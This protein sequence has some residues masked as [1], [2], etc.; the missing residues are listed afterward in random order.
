MCIEG[1]GGGTNRILGGI[2]QSLYLSSC[3]NLCQFVQI[4][5]RILY[6]VRRQRILRCSSKLQMNIVTYLTMESRVNLSESI[7]SSVLICLSTQ[8]ISLSSLDGSGLP[9]FLAA[10]ILSMMLAP[11]E[12][13]G[14]LGGPPALAWHVQICLLVP[15]WDGVVG[16]RAVNEKYLALRVRWVKMR[17]VLGKTWLMSRK[18]SRKT[19]LSEK[20]ISMPC[21]RPYIASRYLI[22]TLLAQSTG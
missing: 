8:N 11:S 19:F 17:C 4:R 18:R 12:L 3:Y 15:G 21:V 13:Q 5:W 22:S 9:I 2:E 20:S 7:A 6:E 16:L 1:W 10:T 14:P